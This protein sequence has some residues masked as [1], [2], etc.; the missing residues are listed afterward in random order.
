MSGVL[1]IQDT[2]Y[3]LIVQY[4]LLQDKYT[5]LKVCDLAKNYELTE[6][7]LLPLEE[8]ISQS[9]NRYHFLCFPVLLQ[10]DFM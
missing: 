1:S 2:E 5:H 4:N 8:M 7:Y 10:V 3:L 9:S 6:T